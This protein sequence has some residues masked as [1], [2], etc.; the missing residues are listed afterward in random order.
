MSANCIGRERQAQLQCR[1]NLTSEGSEWDV[2]GRGGKGV[3]LKYYMFSSSSETSG[4]LRDTPL[5]LAQANPKD[6]GGACSAATLDS[7]T[8]NVSSHATEQLAVLHRELQCSVILDRLVMDGID[9][10]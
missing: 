5:L 8:V 9:N 10:S 2:I 1:Q 4:R 6:L 7:P 3:L